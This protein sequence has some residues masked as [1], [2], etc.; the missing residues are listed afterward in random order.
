[1]RYNTQY[2][3]ENMNIAISMDLHGPHKVNHLL[4]NGIH[5][6]KHSQQNSVT[7]EDNFINH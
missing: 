1:M 4:Q 3:K 7:I 5:G 6:T 2:G